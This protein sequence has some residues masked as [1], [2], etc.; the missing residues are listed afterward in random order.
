MLFLLANMKSAYLATQGQVRFLN[1]LFSCLPRSELNSSPCNVTPHDW[2]HAWQLLESTA[3]CHAKRQHML[4]WAASRQVPDDGP[5]HT[6]HRSALSGLIENTVSPATMWLATGACKMQSNPAMHCRAGFNGW[7]KLDAQCT[8]ALSPA[9]PDPKKDTTR[10]GHRKHDSCCSKHG[11][12]MRGC[13][14]AL[15]LVNIQRRGAHWNHG[16]FLG[17][18]PPGL[19]ISCSKH[20]GKF[21]RDEQYH[22]HVMDRQP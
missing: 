7:A 8:W 17:H 10:T 5:A 14:S 11:K 20:R 9:R 15:I 1:T 22:C 19:S 13:W 4:C 6:G 21:G 16:H 3:L 2:G 12:P 18:T